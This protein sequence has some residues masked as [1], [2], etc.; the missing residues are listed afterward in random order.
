[1]QT[2]VARSLG[3]D[4]PI[5]AFSHCRDVVVAVSRAGGIGVL[6][7][8]M[9]SQE[10]F[11]IDLAWIDEHIG[12]KPYGVDLIIPAKYIGRGDGGLG[13]AELRRMLPPEQVA[14]VDDM[15]RRYDV[16]ELPPDVEPPS[17]ILSWSHQAAGPLVELAFEHPIALIANALG[18]PPPE[19]V[20]TAHER[21]IAVA[22]LVGTAE[23]AAA[24]CEA[25]VDIVVAQGYEAGGHTGDIGTMVLVPEVVDAVWP[26]PVLAAG[27]IGSGRQMLA[28]MA[29]GAQ[30]VWCGSVWL[31]TDEAETHPVVKQKMLGAS[32]R[33]T[34]RS[35][36]RTGK[37][38]RQLVSAW[39]R[40]WEA[41]AAPPAL[42]M[43]LQ[44]LLSAEAQ[45]R[46]DRSAHTHRGAADLINYFVGQVVGS[47]RASKSSKRVVEDMVTEFVDSLAAIVDVVDAQPANS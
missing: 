43:P 45:A 36:A 11:A 17:G 27:G 38:A 10:Q 12:G 47:M 33:D 19:I 7:A 5:F 40:E 24:Q 18:P 3:L 29:L 34:V 14:F 4:V 42:P 13:E 2:S 44:W 16:P 31:T 15:L 37:P 41:P 30:G 1:M 39:T 35:R 26:L 23:Q 9:H 21:G 20:A 22:A 25:G 8:V 46:I 6:G 32:S 28:A